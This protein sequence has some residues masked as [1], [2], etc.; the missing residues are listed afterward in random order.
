MVAASFNPNIPY[1]DLPPLPPPGVDLKAAVILQAVIPARVALAELNRASKQL[2]DPALILT[3]LWLREARLS[4]EIENIVTTNDDLFRAFSD[5]VELSNPATKE[6]LRYEQALS[7]GWEE[8]RKGRILSTRL[9]EE[10]VVLLRQIEEGVR[11][12]AGTKIINPITK[13]VLYTP[14]VGEPRI[15]EHL[16]RL[17]EYIHTENDVDPLVVL[18][19]L[20]YQFEAIHPFADGNGRTGRIINVLYLLSKG[21]LSVPV[22]YLS[23]YFLSRRSGYYQGLRNITENERWY[24][25]IQYILEGVRSTS[26]DTL[27]RIDEILSLKMDVADRIKRTHP[28]IYSSELIDIMFKRPY[29]KIRFL[30]DA[31][32]AKRQTASRY[33]DALAKAGIL[34]IQEA[35][36]EKYFVN[37]ELIRLLERP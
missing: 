18:A 16:A 26:V 8:M 10:L 30:V 7:Y 2:P 27:K 32:I 24:D 9:F 36:R 5:Q 37:R 6:V 34:E 31:G 17:E 11:K 23:A 22:L 35:A 19:L 4:S 33:L 13:E 20:H 28:N 1:N 3:T 25:W 14:P 29:V 15:R 12:S 21:L